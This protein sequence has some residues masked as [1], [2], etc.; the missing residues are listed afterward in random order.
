MLGLATE[1]SELVQP[2]ERFQSDIVAIKHLAKHV[3]QWDGSLQDEVLKAIQHLEEVD[4]LVFSDPEQT[5]LI[6]FAICTAPCILQN[7]IVI[8]Y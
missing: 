8:N 5:I 4:F 1:R 2:W 7:A 6:S 3:L